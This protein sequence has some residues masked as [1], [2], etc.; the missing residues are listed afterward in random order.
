MAATRTRKRAP[1]R[2]KPA[3]RPVTQPIAAF[4]I[5]DASPAPAVT[6]DLELETA[7]A[8]VTD[9]RDRA[10]DII[11]AA[12]EQAAAVQAEAETAAARAV[13]DTHEQVTAVTTEAQTR[14]AS[15]TAGADREAAVQRAA[16]KNDL[17]TARGEADRIL[18]EARDRANSLVTEARAQVTNL[19]ELAAT[20]REATGK[21]VAE[22]LASA[23]LAAAETCTRATTDAEQALQRART[24]AE[25]QLREARTRAAQ[26][27]EDA[28]RERETARQEAERARTLV[29]EDIARLRKTTAED[30]DRVTRAAREEADRL[31]EA[32]RRAA[33]GNRTAAQELLADAR[34]RQEEAAGT[35]E[36]A[37]ALHTQATEQLRK[38]TSRTEQRLERQRLKHAARTERRD[39]RAARQAAAR[40]EREE[41]RSGRPTRSERAKRFLGINAERLMVI[42]PITAPMAVAWTGQ[43]GFAEDILGW[44]APFTILFAAAW[45]LST[46]FVG[47]MY[48]QARR[49]ADAGTLYRVSTWV[50]ACGAAVMNF[51]HASGVVTG[52]NFNEATGKWVDQV[53]Y[54][55]ATPKAVAFAAM[56]IVGMVLWEL[57]A[58]LL[59][60]RQLRRDGKVATA[61][62]SIGVVRWVR[63][64]R[65]A[66][67]AWSLAITDSSLSTLDRAW[68]AAIPVLADRAAVRSGLALHRVVVPRLQAD[69]HGPAAIPTVLTLTR[70]DRPVPPWAGSDQPGP[71]RPS[72][73]R[74][75]PDGGY[76]VHGPV[77]TAPAVDR[78]NGTVRALEPGPADR[79]TPGL[80]GQCGP[81]RT[82]RTV[83][84]IRTASGPRSVTV[85]TD[86]PSPAADRTGPSPDAD[87]AADRRAARTEPDRTAG[88]GPDRDGQDGPEQTVITLTDRERTALDQLRSENQPLNRS[89]IATAIRSAGGSIATDRAG[90]IA[91]A[92]KQHAVR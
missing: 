45:E 4:T 26:V 17:E 11:D 61:R 53:T 22:L 37:N 44:V 65:H 92:L 52:Q 24:E 33:E 89:N 74:S 59:H 40:R 66:F 80:H 16:A 68:T 2:K 62:P 7:Q 38:A 46:A 49:D 15:I 31:L 63:Y 47:W 79:T 29:Q 87:H 72:A 78:A 90:Q 28:D 18:A 91:A 19:T 32:A 10:A 50:F 21:A 42:G 8:R 39:E 20:D 58:S 82:A 34:R 75:G 55:H 60:R 48:H 30:T 25:Q 35:Q 85:R 69:D 57:Y 86:D 56:S 81:D 67:T 88:G 14:A 54:W 27:G 76:P 3:T 71:D 6:T 84:A 43:A 1:A 5:P 9:A 73:A 64:P 77:R 41:S 36:A 13:A 12:R 51:W 83:P 70:M 23:E